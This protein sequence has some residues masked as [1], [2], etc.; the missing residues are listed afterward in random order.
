MGV[1][2]FRDLRRPSAL[3]QSSTVLTLRSLSSCRRPLLD[4]AWEQ[5]CYRRWRERG[6]LWGFLSRKLLDRETRYSTV[7]KECLAMKWAIDT[8]R[9]IICW[10]GTSP[11]K[12]IIGLC[13]G[14]MAWGMPTC[15]SLDGTW[16]CS[17]MTSRWTTGQGSPMWWQT[18]CPE[19][20]R[21]E[22][23]VSVGRGRR[24]C[25][26]EDFVPWSSGWGVGEILHSAL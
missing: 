25:N 13:S 22:M 6:D 3:T 12:L 1:T 14:G 11:W 18:V 20:R 26:E 5:C 9:Y 21:I 19:C 23:L 2:A 17:L 15:A 10:D 24:K 16:P 7:D 4:W 8:L